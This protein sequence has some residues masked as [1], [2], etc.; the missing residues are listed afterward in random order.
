MSHAVPFASYFLG[1]DSYQ[2]R[3]NIVRIF[4]SF[5]LIYCEEFTHKKSTGLP[6]LV[7]LGTVIVRGGE[8]GY[9][10]SARKAIPRDGC[11]RQLIYVLLSV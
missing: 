9:P 1:R 4:F 7:P 2:C 8:L 10:C 6:A 5:N 11:G 3:L